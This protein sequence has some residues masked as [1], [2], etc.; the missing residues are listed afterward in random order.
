MNLLKNYSLVWAELGAVFLGLASL[1]LAPGLL[2]SALRPLWRVGTRIGGCP[3]VAWTVTLAAPLMMRLLAWPIAKIPA[4]TVHDEFSYLLMADTFASGRLANPTHPMWIHFETMHVLQRPTYASMYPVMQG[5]F[6]ALGQA[7]AQAPWLGV[8]LSVVLMCG[9][10]YWALRAWMPAVWALGGAALAA[11]RIGMF[12]YWMNSYWG[13]APAAIGG[14][15]VLGALPRVLRFQRIKDSLLLATGI[16]VLANS[17]PYEGLIYCLPVAVLLFAWIFGADDFC[18]W[19]GLTPRGE[20]GF[21]RIFTRVIAPMALVLVLAGI[22][23]T[24]YFWRVT[25]NPLK[26]PYVADMEQYSITPLFVWQKLKPAPPYNN[27]TL[28]YFYTHWASEQPSELGRFARY[29]LFYVGPALTPPLAMAWISWRDRKMRFFLA[30]CTFVVLA[31]AIEWWEGPHYAAPMTAALYAVILQGL[32]HLRAA[33]GRHGAGSRWR[34]LVPLVPAVIVV[35]IAV[36]FAMPVFSIVPMPAG[37]NPVWATGGNAS[38]GRLKVENF[39]RNKPG[40]HLVLIRYVDHNDDSS[41]HDEWIYNRAN[42][43]DSRIVWA[44]E[45]DEEHNRK[46]MEYFKD[47]EIWLCSWK[48][49]KLVPLN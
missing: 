7:V 39:L 36:R 14:A 5:L 42:I 15:L 26:M 45:L 9:T 34:G 13:G 31:L 22:A 24:Y 12:S 18:R 41:I 23:M 47:R 3:K 29:W 28:R 1:L 21:R 32:R 8:W 49:R 27:E 33:I 19:F 38:S 48:D 46:L 6:L 43:D 40:K 37:R 16:V 17:R 30:L 10:F 4:P 11:V 25:G 2:T 44:R 35:M 20:T